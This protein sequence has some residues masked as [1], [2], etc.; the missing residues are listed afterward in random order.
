MV[1]LPVTGRTEWVPVWV[2]GIQ[3]TMMERAVVPHRGTPCNHVCCGHRRIT[4]YEGHAHP[5]KPDA[6]QGCWAASNQETRP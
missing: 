5:S 4:D 1:Y 2:D 6:C 3:I